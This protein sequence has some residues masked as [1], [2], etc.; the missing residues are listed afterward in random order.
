[1]IQVAELKA[2]LRRLVRA[3]DCY[4]AGLNL[5]DVRELP[6]SCVWL[7]MHGVSSATFHYVDC[8]NA[9]LKVALLRDQVILGQ[10]AKKEAEQRVNERLKRKNEALRRRNEQLRLEVE[11][12]LK[13]IK[14][15]MAS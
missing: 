2:T 7:G 8:Q 14:S 11:S 10:E 4:F 9:V 15:I 13:R 6:H 5:E 3:C 1:M 12:Q